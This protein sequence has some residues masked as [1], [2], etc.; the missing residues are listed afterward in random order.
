MSNTPKDENPQAVRKLGRGGE[1]QARWS[2]VEPEVWNERMLEAL[3]KGVQ[4][5]RWHNLIDKVWSKK[6]LGAAWKKVKA[7]QGS[8]GVDKQPIA[9]FEARLDDQLQ[10]LHEGLRAGDF[11]PM[12]VKRVWI[13][14]GGG[15][16]RP[17]GIPTVRDRVIQ[18]SLRH[19]IEPIFERKFLDCSYGFRPGR[20]CKDALREVDRLLK[21][22][23]TWVVDVD[24]EQYF[25]SIPHTKLLT[26]VAREIA[27]GKVLGLIEQYM[28]AGVMEDCK[29][30]QPETGTPQGAVMS[31]LLA[32]IYLHPVD[33]IISREFA[34]VRYADDM[35]ILCRTREEAEA[36]FMKLRDQLEVRELRLHPEKTRIA[37]AT[38]RP[39]FEF[40]GY[41]FSAGYR[42]PRDSSVKKLKNSIREKTR[43]QSGKS[44]EEI[45]RD[46]SRT[47][48]GWFG[49]FKHSS[50]HAFNK[51]E[52]WVRMRMRSVLRKRS[53]RRGVGRGLDH[54]RWTNYYL[55]QLGLFSLVRAHELAIQSS[56][57][58]D[59]RA[60]CGRSARPVRRE[61]ET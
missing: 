39:G 49:Y 35:V 14:K 28:K 20:G 61:G 7:N 34:L 51:I 46:V 29:L 32:N 22:G 44:T 24:I 55:A 40:L 33:E 57:T 38:Q 5:G 15:K 8:A 36:A 25:D 10:Q 30:W 11:D 3:E 60:G 18:G 41:R 26:E 6:A 31:P 56:K 58:I 48:A 27:D 19:A 23:Y 4:G 12:P 9:L 59:R 37:D 45:T 47:L 21:A 2:W 50:R 54:F 52:S 42:D 17:L 13:P 43:R 16:L 1:I 53:K